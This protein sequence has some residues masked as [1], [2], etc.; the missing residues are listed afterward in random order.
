MFGDPRA[1]ASDPDR[2]S[3]AV[4]LDRRAGSDHERSGDFARRAERSALVVHDR[5]ERDVDRDRRHARRPS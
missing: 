4:G 2:G 3:A 5:A 1:D